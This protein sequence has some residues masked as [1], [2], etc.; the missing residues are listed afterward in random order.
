MKGEAAMRQKERRRGAVEKE[1]KVE[2]ALFLCRWC[3]CARNCVFASSHFQFF[4]PIKTRHLSECIRMCFSYINVACVICIVSVIC[5]V[6]FCIH[7]YNI[8][9]LFLFER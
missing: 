3:T 5:N 9:V 2:N 6:L 7:A 1:R 8:R 4:Y